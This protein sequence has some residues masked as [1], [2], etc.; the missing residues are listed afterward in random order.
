MSDQC[1]SSSVTA[2]RC[3]TETIVRL[4]QHQLTVHAVHGLPVAGG[5]QDHLGP[6]QSLKRRVDVL[7]LGVDVVGRLQSQ[8]RYY[9]LRCPRARVA[10]VFAKVSDERPPLHHLDYSGLIVS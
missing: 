4:Q 8:R 9:V 1:S 5:A 3:R 2:A 6:A 7:G 10:E